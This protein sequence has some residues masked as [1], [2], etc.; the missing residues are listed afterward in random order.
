VERFAWPGCSV[1]VTT[2]SPLAWLGQRAFL[3]LPRADRYFFA[4]AV[5][6]LVRRPS[7]VLVHDTIP[8]R[9]APNAL[10]R[11]LW[12][13]YL[14]RSVRSATTVLVDSEATKARVRSDLGVAS[15]RTLHLPADRARSERLR[16]ARRARPPDPDLM[17]YVGRARPHKNLLRAI[18]AFEAS[19][20]KAG[21][22]RFV[23]V[24]ADARG[25]SLL[26]PARQRSSGR[27]E[28]VGQCSDE[29]VE[30]YVAAASFTIQ[31]SLE[32]GF[33][34]TVSEALDAGIPVCCSDIDPLVGVAGGQAVLFDPLSV[35]AIT[36]AIDDTAVAA[37]NGRVPALVPRP[38]VTEFAAEI[39]QALGHSG[40][41]GAGDARG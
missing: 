39:L 8:V 34:L 2:R 19:S 41:G 7:A 6:P 18:E 31:P 26:E 9:W 15:A 35:P 13:S 5:R 11:R 20:F 25:R 22:G 37:R 3:E 38:T 17:V 33:G 16:A 30:R 14:R 32:E 40:G 1:V 21:G 28:V 10:E 24:G 4:H 29:E 36:R 27:V 12:R 23:V